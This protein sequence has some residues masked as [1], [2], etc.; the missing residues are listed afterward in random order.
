MS[1]NADLDVI[2]TAR[3]EQNKCSTVVNDKPKQGTPTLDCY[4]ETLSNHYIGLI[5][6]KSRII[7]VLVPRRSAYEERYL[8]VLIPLILIGLCLPCLA[9]RWDKNDIDLLEED[10]WQAVMRERIMNLF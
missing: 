8:I 2:G 7:E 5:N 3:W 6:D 9:M 1:F 4:C 10:P